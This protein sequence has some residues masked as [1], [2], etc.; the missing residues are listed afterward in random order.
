[1]RKQ[2]RRTLLLFSSNSNLGELERFAGTDPGLSSFENQPLIS[3]YVPEARF[4]GPVATV[5]IL[6]FLILTAIAF[7]RILGLD[8]LFN[9]AMLKWKEKR[10]YERRNETIEARERLEAAFSDEDEDEKE[11]QG[12]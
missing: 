2:F 1:M 4:D 7:D 5:S 8:R 10:A 6:L 12:R 9:E 11:R 3:A